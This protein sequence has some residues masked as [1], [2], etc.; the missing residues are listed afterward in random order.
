MNTSPPTP[1]C[2][3]AFSRRAL[4]GG[5]AVLTAGAAAFGGSAGATTRDT[6]TVWQLATEWREPRG[7]HGK[8]RLRSRA[9]RNAARHR[10]ALTRADAENMNLHKCSWAPAVP[11]VVSRQRFLELW[12]VLAYD[13]T[14]PWNGQTVR[15]LDSRHVHRVPNGADRFAEAF[16]PAD[17]PPS[18]QPPTAPEGRSDGEASTPPGRPNRSAGGRSTAPTARG[19]TGGQQRALGQLT[20]VAGAHASDVGAPTAVLASTGVSTA[21]SVLAGVGLLAA[22]VIVRRGRRHRELPADA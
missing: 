22:G 18:G 7:P 6:I 12:D 13:W 1:E 14:N 17:A 5:V 11:V 9:S 4:L 21:P 3:R 2:E 16:E 20:D 15:L 10:F 19:V 8:T